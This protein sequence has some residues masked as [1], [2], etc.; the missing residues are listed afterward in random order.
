MAKLKLFKKSV[1]G[2]LD[3]ISPD[4]LN[5]VGDIYINTIYNEFIF[6]NGTIE[7]PKIPV[8]EL[9]VADS[10][11]I[12]RAIIPFIPEFLVHH[13]IPLKRIPPADQHFLHFTRVFQGRL[14]NFR[15]L[16]KIDLKFSGNPDGI[17][18]KGNS[19]F[20][21][22]YRTDRIYYKSRLIPEKASSDTFSPLRLVKQSDFVSDE[23]FF[24][25]TLFED[26]NRNK[27]SL[28]ICEKLPAEIFAVSPKLYPFL[29]YDYFTACLNVLLPTEKNIH[30]A[31]LIFEP[32]FFFIY[33]RF[34]DIS[35]LTTME[36]IHKNFG[37][38][39][40][41]DTTELVLSEIFI[42]KLKKYFSGLVLVQTEE[43]AI[44][45]WRKF[46]SKVSDKNQSTE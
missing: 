7:I 13:K 10:G 4:A 1:Q 22:S 2:I 30:D 35:E 24:I 18:A 20:Y 45:R 12:L 14:I 31:I 42:E 16:F 15:H 44:K 46:E 37:D 8:Q 32:L 40:N 17:I 34:K 21:P 41:P 29:V 25:S 23:N 6:I 38:C 36:E 28:E 19:S 26:I 5:N 27:L 43:M 39:F 33:S 9:N 11:K 3:S